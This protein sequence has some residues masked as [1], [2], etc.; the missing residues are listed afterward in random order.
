MSSLEERLNELESKVSYLELANQQ[1]S[2]LIYAQQ[3]QFDV[4]MQQVT[5]QL[6]RLDNDNPATSLLDE[7]PPH[8]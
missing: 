4:H 1:M 7:V 2:D 5:A 6:E 8:Y 3:K